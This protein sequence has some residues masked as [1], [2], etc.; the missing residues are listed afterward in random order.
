VHI[1]R[2]SPCG[3]RLLARDGRIATFALRSRSAR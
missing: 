1:G 3:G 2:A